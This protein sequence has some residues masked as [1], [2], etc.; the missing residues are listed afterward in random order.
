MEIFRIPINSNMITISSNY[1]RCEVMTKNFV[2]KKCL[3]TQL[4]RTLLSNNLYRSL[5]AY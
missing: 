3:P 4:H 5:D 1:Y 2:E